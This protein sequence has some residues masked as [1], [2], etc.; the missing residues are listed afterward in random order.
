MN[1]PIVSFRKIG[2]S[3]EESSQAKEIR[4]V[5]AAEKQLQENQEGVVKEDDVVAADLSPAKPLDEQQEEEIDET[6]VLKFLKT[7]LNKEVNSLD[8]LFIE[9]EVLPEDVAAFHNFKKETGRGIND[10]LIVQKDFTMLDE[11]SKLKEFLKLTNEGLD[12]SD[13]ED[14]VGEYHYDEDF[15]D[16]KEVKKIKL[17]KKKALVEADKFFN[18]MQEK[19]KQPLESK[20]IALPQAEVEELENYRN[21][22]KEAKSEQDANYKRAELFSKKTDELFSQEFKGFE[23]TIDNKKYVAPLGNP[24]ELKKIQSSAA[25]FINKFLDENGMIKDAVGYHKGLATAMNPDKVAKFFYDLGRAEQVEEMD[26]G[27]KNINMTT[28]PVSTST[29]K[30]GLQFRVLGSD[31]GGSGLKV[32]IKT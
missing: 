31:T 3:E 2:S 23:F 16:E 21:A 11:D 30:D 27:V 19:Y 14:M 4:I 22:I 26:K 6:K 10:F 18:E 25:N 5:E 9:R 32:R 28:K 13:V 20:A 12:E 7:K 29:K 17:K 24:D 8:E 1:D 15:D